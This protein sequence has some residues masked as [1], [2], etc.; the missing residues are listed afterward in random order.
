[1]ALECVCDGGSGVHSSSKP[2]CH[3]RNSRSE[4]QHWVTGNP[5]GLPGDGCLR[6]ETLAWLGRA[7]FG[8]FRLWKNECDPLPISTGFQGARRQSW[9][10]GLCLWTRAQLSRGGGSKMNGPFCLKAHRREKEQVWG[11][12]RWGSRREER[13]MKRGKKRQGGLQEYTLI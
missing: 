7:S 2:T 3:G 6:V 5:S 4:C 9:W 10:G 13:E 11:G 8:S 1:M 12:K